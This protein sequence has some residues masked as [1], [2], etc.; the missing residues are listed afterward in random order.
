MLRV[1]L[2]LATL[3]PMAL[4]SAAADLVIDDFS[5]A[6]SAEAQAA[7]SPAS[8]IP[9][10]TMA[11]GAPWGERVMLM[12]CP[13]TQDVPRAYWD[14]DVTLDLSGH[15]AI[16]LD[17]FVPDPAAV[18]P[19]TLY[20]RVPSGWHT[21]TFALPDSGW[22][23]IRLDRGSF[24]PSG[25]P[26]PWD[27][28][29]GIRLSPWKGGD[30]DTTLAIRDLRAH[31]PEIL[32]TDDLS[33]DNVAEMLT[34]M[35]LE[36]ATVTEAEILTGA[37]AEAR[38]LFIG[39][40]AIL[41]DTAMDAVDSWVASGGR[42]IAFYALPTRL[43]ALL[44]LSNLG[45]SGQDMRAMHF[46][47]PDI[48]G[49]PDVVNQASWNIYRA[50][51]NRAD[52]RVIASWEAID[53]T[54]LSDAAW[55]LSD[56][57]A[58][59]SHVLL[60]DGGAAKRQMLLAIIG[61]FVPEVWP[62]VSQ[63]A[64]DLIGRV[65]PHT[66]YTAAVVS[67]EAEAHHTP[68]L[69]TTEAWLASAEALRQNALAAH[70]SAEYPA[71]VESAG[72]ARA[73]LR[74]AY[75]RS[76]TVWW[77]EIRAC[78]ESRGTG[79]YAGDWPRTAG[80]LADAGF[81][82]VVPLMLWGGLA[83]YPSALLPHSDTY[84]Q[85]GDQVAQCVAACH[86]RGIEVHARKVNWNLLNA[87]QS[88]IDSMRAANRTQ[89]DVN[90]ADVDW[91]CPSDPDNR[92]LELGAMLEV[93]HSYDVDGINLDFIRYPNSNSCFCD[94]CRARFEAH[95]GQ[96]VADWPGDCHGDGPS[97]EAYRDWR[98]EQITGLVRAL[99]EAIDSEGLDVELSADVFS[100]YPACRA[101]VGQDWVAWIDEG[102]LD[103]VCPMDYTNSAS[104]FENLVQSQSELVASRI[105]LVPGIGVS[106]SRS[107]L[108]P[109]QAILPAQITRDLGVQ[110]FILFSLH[111]PLAEETLPAF[112]LGFTAPIGQAVALY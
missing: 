31:T 98:V 69:A 21:N 96:T 66:E 86:A 12:P 56:A 36:Y 34:E 32:L 2:I 108:S 112:G 63:R 41:S 77:P 13:F 53:G 91:L 33:G 4:S 111:A 95:A 49:L 9:E 39:H 72:A 7:W 67:I 15:L 60:N 52:A 79:P 40:E 26:E 105:P 24:S 18:S 20:F 74:Q 85:W 83:H 25:S 30:I 28:V 14:R 43:A 45:W 51:P 68:R 75:Y 54:V 100:G 97:A 37:L 102:L 94:P 27:Q 44:G 6:S 8:G 70:A 19:F 23:S 38:L 5:Y 61:H 62:G 104:Q 11:E 109:D 58:W 82:A 46:D 17:I 64:I 93:I 84:T 65:G 59:M 1:P 99:R 80:V 48:A 3:V 22:N 103:F 29:E 50:E 106:A 55:L 47:A 35:S 81:N 73:S 78:W 101:S 42:V 57:G 92:A 16:A 89:V 90:G 107:T 87:S 88:F 71:A 110:G 76:R 10:V